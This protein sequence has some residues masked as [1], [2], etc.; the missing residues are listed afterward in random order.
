MTVDGYRAGVAELNR[1]A[2]I[3]LEAIAT[4]A[5][6]AA[7]VRAVLAE[8]L[9]ALIDLYGAAVTEFAAQWYEAL[10]VEAGAAGQFTAT[11]GAPIPA[12]QI[13][14][15]IGWASSDPAA[16]LTRLSGALQRAIADQGRE[17]VMRSSLADPAADGWRRIATAE[18]CGFCRMLADRGTVYSA[19]SVAFGAHDH[20]GC[21]AAPAFGGGARDVATH[22]PSTR[23]ISDADRARANA[24]M[25]D[26]GY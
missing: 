18:G 13:E 22:T 10:R 12:E 1:L 26:H 11:P 6:N 20:C 15:M 9:P 14:A 2:A 4:A 5:P 3:D 8:A 16:M 25:R 7:A 17:T 21:V 24:W 19:R 23:P